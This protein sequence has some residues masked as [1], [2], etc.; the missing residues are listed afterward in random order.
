ME[1][2]KR[3]LTTIMATDCVSF[4]KHMEFDELGTLRNLNECRSIIDQ[5]IAEYGGRIFH[6]AGDSVIAEFDSTVNSVKAAYEFQGE[7]K[8]RSTDAAT[9]LP[10]NWRV[11][12]H[13]DDVIV[14]GANIMGCGV[15]IAARLESQCEPTEVLVS[16]IVKEQ[17]ERR[18]EI[19]IHADGTRKLKNISD[20]FEVFVVGGDKPREARATEALAELPLT[21]VPLALTAKKPKIA[22]TPF[23]NLSKQD[24]SEY[25]AEGIFRDLITEFSRMKEF[26]VVSHQTALRFVADYSNIQNAVKEFGID[27]FVNGSIR[28]AGQKI[29]ISVDLTDAIDGANLWGQ[30]YD[31]VMEDIFDIQDEIVLKMSRQ[32]LGNIE[33]NS[34]Q[35]IKRKPSENLNSYEWLV[36]GNYHHV[37]FGKEHMEK[38]I[39]AFDMA[40]NLDQSNARAHALKACTLGA[41]LA[42]GWVNPEEKIPVIFEHV[43]KSQ[44]ADE[45]DF[46]C[47]RI[48]SALSLMEGNHQAAQEHANKA[49][50]I[51]PND[52]R[53]LRQM[54]SVLIVM[55]RA[56]EAL[57]LMHHSFD[58]D[59]IPQGQTT[60]CH[61]YLQFVW[62]Y[63]SME[64]YASCV[65]YGEKI[66]HM[67]RITWLLVLSAISLQADIEVARAH[68]LFIKKTDEYRSE[69]WATAIESL[70]LRPGDS[71]I[72]QLES[73]VRELFSEQSATKSNVASA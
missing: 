39:E 61:N 71:R 19:P 37:R 28:T 22:V 6:T 66:V 10:L 35:R 48:C 38:A 1:M 55:G 16:R 4:S 64:D 17:I 36:R 65:L 13:L 46:E 68:T 12:I 51:N 69:D 15:N 47:L 11:G 56:A 40:I 26:D 59:P 57:K 67:S 42:Y 34:L 70:H 29:R 3:K 63:Y 31:R 44:E 45:D 27:Y 72:E 2:T 49:Y 54:G 7:L 53:V 30:K 60:S 23:E 43:R 18:I 5:K 62:A 73:F 52:P 25:L 33:I 24:D 14:D 21:A 50:R 58:L 8:A 20:Q 9:D 41:G 32:L